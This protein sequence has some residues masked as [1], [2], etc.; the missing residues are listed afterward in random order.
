MTLRFSDHRGL[1]PADVQF[2]S[3]GVVAEP[4]WSKTIGSDRALTMRLVVISKGAFVQKASWTSTGWQLPAEEA[5][6]LPAAVFNGWFPKLQAPRAEVH[7]RLGRAISSVVMFEGP[8]PTA[9]Q[10]Q[11]C[12]ALDASQRKEFLTF[13][14]CGVGVPEGRQGSP[15]G[16]QPKPVTVILGW[17][18][19]GA[20][21]C[22]SQSPKLL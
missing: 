16:G 11:G 17:Q 6:F 18:G 1:R 20:P 8:R 15:R 12:S 13:C 4:T 3:E 5:A 22:N 14:G 9:F 10:P 19:N 2:D 7:L 21:R